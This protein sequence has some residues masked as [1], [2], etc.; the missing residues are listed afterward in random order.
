MNIKNIVN[1]LQFYLKEYGLKKTAKKSFKAIKNRLFVRQDLYFNSE[2]YE[3]WIQNNEPTAEE[4]ELQKNEKFKITPKFSIIV[5]MYNTPLEYFKELIN[6]IMNQTYTNWELCLAD[7]SMKKNEEIEKIIK[8]DERVKYKLLDEN[9]GISGNTNAGLQMATGDYILLLDHD[10]L[11]P[12]F[13]LYEIAKKINEN[14]D[15]EFIYTD[16]DHIEEGKRC[17]PHFKPDFAIDTLRAT[18][19]ITHLSIFKK[20]FMEELGGFKDEYNGAQDYDIILRAI[21][22]TKKI[23][24][25]PK[26]LYNWRIH[27]NSTSMIVDAKPYAYEAGRK[28]ISDHLKRQGIEA[29]VIHG[30]DLKGTY[31]VQYEILGTPSVSIII[32]NKDNVKLLKKCISSILELTTYKNYEIVIVE[33]NSTNKKTFEYYKEIEQNEKVRIL[34]YKEKG[35]NYSKIINYGV[36]NCKSDFIVQLNNDTKLLTPTWLEKFIGFAQREE[37]GAV[38]SKAIL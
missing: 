29:K 6:C 11:L 22:N 21:E 15:L 37:V 3:S 7:G 24:H 10:D 8:K 30:R 33:N 36:Q 18:N 1:A 25:I 12:I 32:P 4:L 31:E 19:Y 17:K 5:P 20:E 27:A 13:C 34:T 23:E 2:N 38:R 26:I 16:E 35:F 14:P 28:A 9:K